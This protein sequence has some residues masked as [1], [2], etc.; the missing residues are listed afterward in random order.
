M[1][2]S[3]LAAE[4]REQIP[5]GTR[6]S[7]RDRRAAAWGMAPRTPLGRPG[8][9]LRDIGPDQATPESMERSALL[10]NQLPNGRHEIETGGRIRRNARKIRVVDLRNC[11][12]RRLTLQFRGSVL[13]S[14]AGLLAYR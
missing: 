1:G 11:L 10:R 12:D 9:V 14:D 3:S 8:R 4:N 2:F 13:T 5:A 6:A 7:P